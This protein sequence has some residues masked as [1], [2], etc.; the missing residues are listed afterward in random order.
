MHG[1]DREQKQPAGYT[2]LRI[3]ELRQLRWSNIDFDNGMIRLRDDRFTGPVGD[4]PIQTLKGKRSRELPIAA[5][6]RPVLEELRRTD[7]VNDGFVFHGATGGRIKPDKV[8]RALLRD[9]LRPIRAGETGDETDGEDGSGSLVQANGNGGG[10][11]G[12]GSVALSLTGDGIDKG[13][14]HS[15]RH[16]FVSTCANNN[17]PEQMLLAWLGHQ[18]SKLIRRYYHVHHEPAKAAMNSIAWPSL[19]A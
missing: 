4:D 7:S 17:V 19:E 9:V 18:N 6:L 12:D 2:G 8:R 13:R 1:L 10:D 11:R 5:P 3:S 16:Y 15:F 14:L